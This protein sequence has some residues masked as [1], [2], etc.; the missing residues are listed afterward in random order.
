MNKATRQKDAEDVYS[1][2]VM[3]LKERLSNDECQSQVLKLALD[4]LK[5]YYT[6]QPSTTLEGQIADQVKFPFKQ[7]K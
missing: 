5:H 2:F 6:D 4:F 3:S 1:L 7:V